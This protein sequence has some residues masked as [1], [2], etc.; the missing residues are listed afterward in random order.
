[1]LGCDHTALPQNKASGYG[2]TDFT[3]A[4]TRLWQAG[5]PRITLFLGQTLQAKLHI[6]AIAGKYR[7]L[8]P[9]PLRCTRWWTH[10]FA[11]ICWQMRGDGSEEVPPPEG[12]AQP[13]PIVCHSTRIHSPWNPLLRQ[14]RITLF[15]AI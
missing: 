12:T 9:S 4:D 7:R 10:K 11:S 13:P 6:W 5:K 2:A 1:M 14:E 8:D 15:K 3:K